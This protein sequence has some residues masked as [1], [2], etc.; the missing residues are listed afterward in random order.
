MAFGRH[1]HLLSRYGDTFAGSY[2]AVVMKAT[3]VSSCD[4]S[5]FILPFVDGAQPDRRRLQLL[6]KLFYIVA[7]QVL[8]IW[9]DR[10]SAG[11]I[12]PID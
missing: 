12:S 2:H 10:A 11:K 7:H 5:P 1:C 9:V 6:N 4:T 8:A 3:T